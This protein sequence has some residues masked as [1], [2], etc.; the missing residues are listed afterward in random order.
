MR[1]APLEEVGL[2]MH[3]QPHPHRSSRNVCYPKT[4][5]PGQHSIRDVTMSQHD[6]GIRKPPN[7]ASPVSATDP[8]D[9]FCC[10]P[11]RGWTES[12]QA[13]IQRLSTSSHHT[14]G[15]AQVQ[16][17]VMVSPPAVQ[18]RRPAQPRSGGGLQPAG[19]V[20]SLP[21]SWSCPGTTLWV[22]WKLKATSPPPVG[23][24]TGPQSLA[25]TGH[26]PLSP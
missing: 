7:A 1:K 13:Q 14:T 5:S 12:W 25:I 18:P 15:S 23:A 20:I 24:S 16:A 11:T 26:S 19:A 17:P 8:Q 9:L 4:A 21:S 2:S 10:L 22:W 3:V 6:C